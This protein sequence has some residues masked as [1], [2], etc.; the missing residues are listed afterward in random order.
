MLADCGRE[1]RPLWS[2]RLS[3]AFADHLEKKDRAKGRGGYSDR[4]INRVLAHLKTFAKWIHKLKPFPLDNPMAKIKLM[5]VGTGLE[6]ERAITA[7]ERRR[8]LDAADS[9]PPVR[10]RSKDRNRYRGKERPMRKRY[11]ANYKFGCALRWHVFLNFPS[12]HSQKENS[13]QDRITIDVICDG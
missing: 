13:F 12:S 8:I 9:L 5:P 7:S 1:D 4:T 2:P 11:P 6:V 3:K 10:G